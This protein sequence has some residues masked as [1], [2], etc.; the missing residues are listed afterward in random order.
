MEGL[1]RQGELVDAICNEV[2]IDR[3]RSPGR[4]VLDKKEAMQILSYIQT[5]RKLVNNTNTKGE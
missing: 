1:E 4:P 5:M 3:R 2:G